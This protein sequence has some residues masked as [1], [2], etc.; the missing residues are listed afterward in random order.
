MCQSNKILE[1]LHEHDTPAHQ[2]DRFIITNETEK[3]KNLAPS[4]SIALYIGITM[5][6]SCIIGSISKIK[7]KDMLYWLFGQTL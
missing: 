7:M 1:I 3:K 6:I 2:F 5:E 4:S